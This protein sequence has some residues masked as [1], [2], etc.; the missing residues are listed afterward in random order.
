MEND[1]LPSRSFYLVRKFAGISKT[2]SV[3]NHFDCKFK[4]NIKLV[5]ITYYMY[6][7]M[8]KK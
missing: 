7:L 4:H 1:G 6:T 3:A 2:N 8:F 5:N